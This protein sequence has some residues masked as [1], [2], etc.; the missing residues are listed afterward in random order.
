MNDPWKITVFYN[1]IGGTLE[2]V[3]MNLEYEK[4]YVFVQIQK[5]GRQEVE[6][7]RI[8]DLGTYIL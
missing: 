4:Q 5:Q 6:Y 2:V 8:G 7:I 3:V 1:R